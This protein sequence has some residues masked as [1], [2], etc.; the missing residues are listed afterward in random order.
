M[1]F[2]ISGSAMKTSVAPRNT[3]A[4][5]RHRPA[6]SPINSVHLPVLQP[7]AELRVDPLLRFR[8]SALRPEGAPEQCRQLAPAEPC[9]DDTARDLLDLDITQLGVARDQRDHL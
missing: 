9:R 2:P 6:P 4:T 8:G 1:D 7:H 5:K 3:A